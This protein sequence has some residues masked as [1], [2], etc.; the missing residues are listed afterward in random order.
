MFLFEDKFQK[1]RRGYKKIVNWLIYTSHAPPKEC[2]CKIAV[3][4]SLVTGKL[5]SF[6]LRED[7]FDPRRSTYFPT[8]MMDDQERRMEINCPNLTLRRDLA[9]N[10]GRHYYD[11]WKVRENFDI[12]GFGEMVKWLP[13]R[14]KITM[15]TIIKNEHQLYTFHSG[16]NY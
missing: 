1:F 10:M 8:D 2:I 16:D 12:F 7:A 11:E 13:G 14:V 9:G 3:S 5:N 4:S 6:M 15:L